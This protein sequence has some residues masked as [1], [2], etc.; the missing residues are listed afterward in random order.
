MP[1]Q[2]GDEKTPLQ[3]ARVSGLRHWARQL[4][5]ELRLCACAFQHPH[6]GWPARLVLGLTLCYALSPLDLI[7]DFIPLLGQLDDLILV[8]LGIALALRLIPAPV[9]ADCRRRVAEN[10]VQ[11]VTRWQRYLGLF[12]VLLCWLLCLLGLFALFPVWTG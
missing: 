10:D 8:P 12:A 1:E 5:Q 11:P 3:A 4:K 2:M 7:P 9:L 6:C